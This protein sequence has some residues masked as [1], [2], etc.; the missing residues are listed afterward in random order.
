MNESRLTLLPDER[1]ARLVPA[2]DERLSSIGEHIAVGHFRSMLD[3]TMRRAIHLGFSEAGADEGTIW[4]HERPTDD[5]LAAAYNTGPKAESFVGHFR[6]PLASG[7]VSMV[8]AS[9][10]PFLENQM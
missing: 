3:D 4:I 10:R 9:Q 7:L 1:F 6:Q 5:V 8:F 2:L